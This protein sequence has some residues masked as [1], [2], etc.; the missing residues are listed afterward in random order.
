MADWVNKAPGA[1]LRLASLLHLADR[2]PTNPGD[3]VAP[4]GLD[5]MQRALL[6]MDYFLAHARIAFDLMEAT[7]ELKRLRSAL[8]WL[9]RQRP[10]IVT[11]RELHRALH[12]E[13]AED[14]RRVLEALDGRGYVR[15]VEHEGPRLPGRPSETYAVNPATWAEKTGGCETEVTNLRHMREPGED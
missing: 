11:V 3:L 7:P 13:N 14:A 9:R 10:A 15:R 4:I 2:A 5:P 8:R 6:L 1:A 12:C